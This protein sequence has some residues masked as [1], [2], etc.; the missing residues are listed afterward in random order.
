MDGPFFSFRCFAAV[1][2]KEAENNN[3]KKK[4]LNKKPNEIQPRN[5]N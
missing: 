5:F 3:E 2:E 1:I 4:N